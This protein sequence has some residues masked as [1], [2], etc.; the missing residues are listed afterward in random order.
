MLASREADCGPSPARPGVGIGRRA[1]FRYRCPYGRVG[2]TPSQGTTFS[3]LATSIRSPPTI[4]LRRVSRRRH[5]AGISKWSKG[6]SG[7]AANACLL[8]WDLSSP[9]R[10]FKSTYRLQSLTRGGA[11]VD[12]MCLS[13]PGSYP[14]GRWFES[15]PRNQLCRARLSTRGRYR[16]GQRGLSKDPSIPMLDTARRIWHTAPHQ[17]G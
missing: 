10:W 8:S 5:P 6:V 2:S 9:Q 7:G 14:G 11:V 16:S 13:S 4:S 12:T 1:G 3:D 17:K 15:I